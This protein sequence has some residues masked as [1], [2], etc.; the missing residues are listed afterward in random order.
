MLESLGKRLMNPMTIKNE[1]DWVQISPNQFVVFVKRLGR[2]D[3]GRVIAKCSNETDA[4]KITE[5]MNR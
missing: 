1:Y 4:T 5:A 2:G 3:G